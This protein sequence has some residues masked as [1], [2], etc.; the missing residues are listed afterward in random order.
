MEFQPEKVAEFKS[1][2]ESRK[3]RIVS[4]PG[5]QHVE[6]LRDHGLPHVYYTLS[7]WDDATDLENYRTS[8]FFE[9]TWTATKKFFAGKP[10]AWSLIP[11]S[12]SSAVSG[13]E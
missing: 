13:E 4:F 3:A 11:D 1:F 7:H 6:L 12:G 10:R 8:F 5:C 2:F 9:E